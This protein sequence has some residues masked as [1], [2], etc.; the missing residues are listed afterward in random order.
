MA[1]LLVP[2]PFA[3]RFQVQHS[4]RAATGMDDFGH[5]AFLVLG[6]HA[7]ALELGVQRRRAERAEPVGAR[8]SSTAW[9]LMSGMR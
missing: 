3:D 1:G 6:D 2:R 8:A 7:Q 9:R 4:L 5:A